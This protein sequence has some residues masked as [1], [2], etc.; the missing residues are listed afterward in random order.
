[1]ISRTKVSLL[2]LVAM[3]AISAIPAAAAQAAGE[4]TAEHYPATMTGSKVTNH[5]FKF[6]MW[7][8]TCKAATLH[9]ELALPNGQ[10]PL[11]AEYGECETNSGRATEIAMTSCNYVLHANE[12]LAEDKV[13]GSLDIRCTEAG[14]AIDFTV[15]FNGCKVSIP[16]QN[17]LNTLT[18]TDNTLAKDFD[19]DI[20]VIEMKYKQNAQCPGG[21]MSASNGEYSGQS[22][23]QADSEGLPVGTTVD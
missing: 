10:L 16:A 5:V 21:A 12:T 14:D 11:T 23:I 22:T 15:P 19:V 6:G 1:M 20:N 7:S 3:V 18:Y 8:V 2:A 17:G 13:D 9:G 4:F